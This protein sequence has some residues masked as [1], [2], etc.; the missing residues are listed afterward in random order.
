VNYR[1]DFSQRRAELSKFCENPAVFR[2]TD[3]GR[4]WTKVFELSWENIRHFHTALADPFHK[5]TWYISSGDQPHECRM[6]RS[7]DDGLTWSEMTASGN[8]IDLH[9][10]LAGQHQSIN[11]H[12]DMVV[13]SDRL[14][15]GSDDLLGR[16]AAYADL[17]ATLSN[18]VG[19]RLF[20]SPKTVP[21]QPKCVAFVG[22]HVRSMV[23]VGSGYVILT[24]AK[25]VE[26]VPRPQVCFLSKAEP[27]TLTQLFTI[28]RYQAGGTGFTFSR[29]SRAAVNGRFFTYRDRND[30]FAGGP[31]LL[32]WDITLEDAPKEAGRVVPASNL[33]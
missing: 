20:I 15:W 19:S 23:D 4:S 5:G 1:S 32:Q 12:T 25:R 31:R 28:D 11:R 24:E 26:A 29:N 7:V 2:S 18:R 10:S 21:L 27:Y 6:W 8:N 30:A 3:E 9:S 16:P 17:T 33:P 13:M 14:I 22:S